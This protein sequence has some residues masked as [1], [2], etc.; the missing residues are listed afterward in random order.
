MY[1]NFELAK[2]KGLTPTDVVNLQLISQNKT[3]NLEGVIFDNIPLRILHSYQEQELVTLIKAKNKSESIH[4][5]VR[6]TPKGHALLE[7]LQVPEVNEDD[8]QLYGWL[9]ST[10][11]REGKE[12]GN[13]KKTKLYIALFRGHSGIDRNKLALLC[14][15]FMNDS[16]QFEW[17]KRLEFLFFKPG[18]VFSVRFDLEQSKLYQYYIKHKE[19]FDDKF[20]KIDEKEND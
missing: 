5:R 15:A 14:K 16:S 3:E 12:L 6:L 17:S 10:Y 19:E 20:K 11:Q 8:L 13:R 18:N 4:N 2:T 1:I 7:D 9:E